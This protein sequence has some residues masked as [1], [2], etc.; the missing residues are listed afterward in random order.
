[1][2]E[3]FGQSGSMEDLAVAPPQML[4]LFVP[5]IDNPA[6]IDGLGIVT[7]WGSGTTLRKSDVYGPSSS[8]DAN[9]T[10]LNDLSSTSARG[11]GNI[12]YNFEGL[13]GPQG[14]AGAPGPPGAVTIQQLFIPFPVG[15]FDVET[16]LKQLTNWGAAPNTM[17][18]GGASHIEWNDPWIPMPIA[19]IKSWNESAIDEDG[20]FMLVASD[21][22]IFVSVNSGEDWSL[23]TPGSES[24]LCVSCAASNGRAV[25]V[26]EESGDYG[27]IWTSSDFGSNWS[28]ITISTE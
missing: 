15:N 18:Y 26:G 16:T 20:S 14:E 5:G 10:L 2:A 1:M 21:Y 22:G 23:K 4:D 8:S 28:E 19:N 9:S 13:V 11:G 25:A 27:K 6:M 3:L 24:T 12:S 17:I 7:P